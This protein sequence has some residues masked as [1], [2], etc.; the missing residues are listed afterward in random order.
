MYIAIALVLS[1]GTSIAYAQEFGTSKNGASN[2][3]VL[4]VKYNGA[5]WNYP[6]SGLDGLHLN[7]LEKIEHFWQ[8]LLTMER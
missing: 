4:Q 8:K 7:I 6:G 5:A 1:V 3:E 2:Y